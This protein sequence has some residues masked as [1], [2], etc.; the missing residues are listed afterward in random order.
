MSLLS[1]STIL[2]LLLPLT[3]FFGGVEDVCAQKPA[4]DSDMSAAT[5]EELKAEFDSLM[6][7]DKL[8]S[9]IF[10]MNTA[11]TEIP[12]ATPSRLS[13]I[14][15]S[16]ARI[17]YSFN[18]WVG[19]FQAE[20]SN[21]DSLL[22]MVAEYKDIHSEVT[23]AIAEA[24][25]RQKEVVDCR[26]ALAYMVKAD[27][28]Y[29]SML[30]KAVALSLTDKT[31]DKLA[32]LK[33]KEKLIA[34]EVDRF[35]QL[36]TDNKEKNPVLDGQKREIEELYLSIKKR[37]AEIQAAEYKPFFQRIKDQLLGIAA[38]SIILMFL[39]MIVARLKA[40]KEMKENLKKQKE[41]MNINNKEYPQI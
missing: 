19:S 18:T 6:L 2:N 37:S 21:N 13:M 14:E 9:F 24:K 29:K 26:D 27:T 33:E 1:K 41:L 7:E 3:L 23:K 25:T 35:Y 4:D 40:W 34:A 39:S 11:L 10:D 22:S 5:E 15:S 8:N 28:I 38:V 16:T 17:D 12:L 32:D 30:E 36:V 20:I 31:A